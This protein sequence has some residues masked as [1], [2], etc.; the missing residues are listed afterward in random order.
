MKIYRWRSDQRANA[1]LPRVSFRSGALA[2]KQQ[3]FKRFIED[4][5]DSAFLDI[6][7]FKER[8]REDAE[9]EAE[10]LIFERYR[11][12]LEEI[13]GVLTL[14]E[15]I[16][17]LSSLMS[18]FCSLSKIFKEVIVSRSCCFITKSGEVRA[19]INSN[20]KSNFI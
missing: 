6:Q 3:Q 10:I 20:P 16:Y 18:A 12:T 2:R 11:C 4:S 9:S 17:T 7:E 15:A 14:P 13:N 8:Q 19:W 1:F 5:S